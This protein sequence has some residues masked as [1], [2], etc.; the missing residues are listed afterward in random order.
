[1]N[2]FC[3]FGLKSEAFGLSML[4]SQPLSR[5]GHFKIWDRTSAE[6][7]DVSR[8]AIGAAE[9]DIRRAVDFAS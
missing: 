8:P 7:A 3:S 6:T 1:M 5:V 4:M 2:R 9:T